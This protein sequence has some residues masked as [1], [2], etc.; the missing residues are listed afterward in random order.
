MKFIAILSV[1][2]LCRCVF[3]EAIPVS[4]SKSPDGRYFLRIEPPPSPDE[5]AA[6]QFIDTQGPTVEILGTYA[7]RAAERVIFFWA[8]DSKHLAMTRIAKHS[9]KTMIFSIKNGKTKQLDLDPTKLICK[10]I[11]AKKAFGFTREGPI[12]WISTERLKMVLSGYATN[13]KND[14][15]R[16]YY[17]AIVVWNVASNSIEFRWPITQLQTDG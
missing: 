10:N 7:P 8:S 2:I 17:E 9:L 1:V 6:I 3:A 14:D 15:H 11:K 16:I 13:Y 12:E 5:P 4:H